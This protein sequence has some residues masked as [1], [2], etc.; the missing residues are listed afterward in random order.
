MTSPFEHFGTSAI[1]A[2]QSPNK[3]DLNQISPPIS[4]STTYKQSEPGV[5][6]GNYDYSRD[7]NPTRIALEEN[8]A[9]LEN[10]SHCKVFPS[11]L[12]AI[13]A[14]LRLV[15]HGEHIICAEDIYGGTLCL[16]EDVIQQIDG[17]EVTFIDF[18][19]NDSMKKALKSNTKL[20][21]FESYT[22]PTLKIVDIEEIATLVKNFNKDILVVVDNTFITPYF[23]RPLSFGVDMVMHSC[24]KYIN[25]HGDVMM[26]VVMTNFEQLDNHLHLMQKTAG[27]IP[28]PFDCFLAMRGTKTLHVRMRVH[29]ENALA[30]AK[31]LENSPK[32]E[33][34]IFPLFE[35]HPQ[36]KIH[37]KQAKGM[38]GMVSFYIKG[39]AEETNKFLCKL[40]LISIAAS[41]GD[42]ESI[43]MAPLLMIPFTA[44]EEALKKKGIT[45]N[46]VRFSV[47]LEEKEDLIADLKQ[48]LEDS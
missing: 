47:G 44:N 5:F 33:K 14:I 13:S 28:S 31:F 29:M 8:L 27:S 41:L 18:T 25:G 35:S 15:K 36:H 34:V 4:L 20:V 40:K 38:S 42:V 48:A 46:L 10:A 30:I 26:G 37:M 9:A 22:N 16:M 19:N 7:A 17:I 23:Q 11:G 43:I 2:G 6:K 3:W 21:L 39:G 45:P 1:H 12:A 32:I 24:T